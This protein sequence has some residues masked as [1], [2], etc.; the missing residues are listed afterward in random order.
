MR[1]CSSCK[2]PETE[3]SFSPKGIYCRACS[4][5]AHREWAAKNKER[6]RLYSARWLAEH[7]EAVNAKYRDRKRERTQ[8]YRVANREK[9]NALQRE[10]RHQDPA[11][12]AA[13]LSRW[14][15]K[16]PEKNV[17]NALKYEA[18]K[19]GAEGSHTLEEWRALLAQHDHKCA[20]CGVPI[21]GRN[22][23][24]D[25]KIPLSRHGTDRIENIVPACRACNSAKHTQTHDEFT[26]PN[27]PR[28]RDPRPRRWPAEGCSRPE[29]WSP[30]STRL[31][32]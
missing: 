13:Y 9:V 21:T 28:E 30:S 32:P 7:R 18:R 3:T 5:V 11:R 8:A 22:A 19:K 2:L 17:H 26:R 6:L 31:R 29:N 27:R 12:H 23:T 4:A 24:R 16:Y 20:Y 14:R 10:R 1:T 15:K 25:H